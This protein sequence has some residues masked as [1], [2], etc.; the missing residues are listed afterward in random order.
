MTTGVMPSIA[1]VYLGIVTYNSAGDLPACFAAL[2]RQTYPEIRIVILDNAS[3]DE[4]VAWV[5]QHASDCTLLTN[6]GNVG[7]GRAHNQIVAQCKPGAGDFYMPLNPDVKLSDDYIERVVAAL[8]ETGA[9]WASGKLLL[10]GDDFPARVYSAG[11]GVCR[12][13]YVINVGQGMVDSADFNEPRE[14]FFVSGAAPVLRGELIA[15][16]APDDELFDSSMFM[17]AEDI[18]MGWRARRL[19]W[20]CWYV[21]GAVARHRGGHLHRAMRAQAQANIHVSV[22]KNAYW[23]DLITYNIPLILV[24]LL[25]RLILTPAMGSRVLL[26]VVRNA[27]GAF[28]KRRKPALPRRDMLGW[29]HWSSHQPTAQ[30][31][32]AV[33]RV[34]AYVARRRV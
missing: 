32:G 15:A 17:Y 29:Y 2:A 27:P 34:R 23:I 16:V 3:T 7:F 12:D 10:P 6:S 14:V 24:D 1:T 33:E 20:R 13:G 28:R 4:T 25:L 31:S 18:D 5:R 11:Q 30:Q 8:G 19:G 21:P 26:Q 22:L 9:G